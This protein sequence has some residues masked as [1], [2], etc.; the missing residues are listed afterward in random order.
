MVH[1]GWHS[2]WPRTPFELTPPGVLPRNSSRWSDYYTLDLR[3]SWTWQFAGGDLSAVV[4]VTN[5][6]NRPNECCTVLANPGSPPGFQSNVD[7]W[8][9]ALVNIG[10]TYR[11]RSH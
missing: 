11:W 8:L 3:G 7:P 1:A 9:P 10:F 6:T 2:G 4:D 5:A